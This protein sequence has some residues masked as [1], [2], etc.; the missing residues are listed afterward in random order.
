MK[1]GK[2]FNDLMDYYLITVLIELI[3]F[4]NKKRTDLN[5]LNLI[6]LWIYGRFPCEL[7]YLKSYK[8]SSPLINNDNILHLLI[9]MDLMMI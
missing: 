3:F 5:L 9:L 2:D 8:P 4:K 1:V 6:F 7:S